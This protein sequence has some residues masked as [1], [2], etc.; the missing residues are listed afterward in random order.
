MSATERLAGIA[1]LYGLAAFERFRAA[2]VTVIGVGGVGSWAAESLARSGIGR[3]VLIDPDDVCLTNSNRQLHAHDGH[4]GRPKVAVL[5]ERFRAIN[6]EL[7]VVTHAEFF[8]ARNADELLAPAPAAVVDAIDAVRAKC[9]LIAHCRAAGIPVVV[10][11]GAGGLKD[12]TRVRVDDLARSVHDPLLA[13]VRRRLRAEFGF[14]KARQQGRAPKFGVEAVF[15]DETP[16]YPTP[17]GGT[18]CE[19]PA[20]LPAG[21]RCDAGFGTATHLTASFGLAAAARVLAR[22]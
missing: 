9:E 15:S 6:P 7:E 4:Y 13:Q 20:E 8:S 19:R 12:P 1:R 17:E 14:P 22:L 3:L 18:S 2:T 5:A 11:G 10:S 16:V 21:L